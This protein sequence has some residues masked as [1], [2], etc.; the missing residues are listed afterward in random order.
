[1]PKRRRKATGTT[2]GASKKDVGLRLDPAIHQ[3][4]LKAA[5]EFNAAIVAVAAVCVDKGRKKP[6]K[7]KKPR[8]PR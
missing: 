8:T 3:R 5:A 4:L 2:G 7:R 6:R 1:M